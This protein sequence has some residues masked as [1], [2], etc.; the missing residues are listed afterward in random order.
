MRREPACGIAP[1]PSGCERMKRPHRPAPNVAAPAH[2]PFGIRTLF[3]LR[4]SARRWPVACRAALSIGLL[5]AVGWLTGNIAA[6]LTATIGAF[7]SLYAS[8]RP[9]HNRARVLAGIAL[10]FA[11]VVS[12][13]MAVQQLPLMAVPLLVVIAM[14]A[15]FVC[16]AIKIG[17]PGAYMFALACAAGTSMPAA[18][19][20]F[21]HAGLLVLAGGAVSWI[22]HMAGALVS[23]R[24]PERA[25]VV[26]AAQAVAQFAEAV[27]AGTDAD[28]NA[29]ARHDAALS[30]HAAWATLVSYQSSDS[31]RDAVLAHLLALNRELHLLFAACVDSTDSRAASQ[32]VLADRAREVG[33]RAASPGEHSTSTYAFDVPLGRLRSTELIREAFR[34]G[35]PASIVA[36][37]V[38]IAVAVAGAIGAVLGIERAYWAM[39]AAVLVLHQGLDW[40]R[41]VR[42]GV[43]RT[44]GTLVGLG[45]ASAIFAI[46]PE[47]PWLALTMMSLQ[48][49]V[50]MLVTRNYAF[51]VVFVTSIALL[52]AS[53]GQRVAEPGALLWARGLDT[54]IGCGVGLLVYMFF[55]S[56]GSPMSIRQRIVLTLATVQTVLEHLASGCVTTPGGLRARRDLQHGI[57]ALM[58]S[59]EVEAG[60]LAGERALIARMRPAIFATQRLGYKVL[61]A[62]WVFEATARE[63]T[64]VAA[65]TDASPDELANAAAVLEEIIGTLRGDGTG[66]AALQPLPDF[67]RGEIEEL[68]EWLACGSSNR[69]ANAR[70]GE[71]GQRSAAS[72]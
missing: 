69:G 51:A 26:A 4:K 43:E 29:Q 47:G 8:E 28:A 52:I 68:R 3:S 62:C 57:F 33:R 11:V 6:G 17:P 70:R 9:Y 50:E 12:L 7:T 38:G 60:G 58:E 37:R 10:S 5:V 35:S 59:Y 30:L 67:L 25:A 23:P 65:S 64:I 1:Y 45:L 31:R 32:T 39:A 41:T 49:L 16:H 40:E 63:R 61:A 21:Y 46:H 20:A 56:R 48:F 2:V 24:G 36:A 66:P 27:D 14:V 15:T 13:G 34:S 53:G 42:R 44:I 22:V 72:S 19:M 71:D 55:K 54:A 18:H